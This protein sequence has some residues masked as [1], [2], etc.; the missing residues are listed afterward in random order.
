M[1]RINWWNVMWLAFAATAGLAFSYQIGFDPMRVRVDKDVGQVWPAWLQAVGSVIALGVAIT[2]P[3]RLYGKERDDLHRREI[4]EEQMR[5]RT[6]LLKAKAAA[7]TLL[8]A[9]RDFQSALQDAM[10]QLKDP[11]VEEYSWIK[12]KRLEAALTSFRDW[13]D[14]MPQMGKAGELG[15]DAIAA[16][17][18]FI[19]V[20]SDW[21]F[22]QTH[23]FNGKIDD[24]E[25]G[26]YAEFPEPPPLT[27]ILKRGIDRM[28]ESLSTMDGLFD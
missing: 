3:H 28:N 21:D 24:P 5:E 12:T 6:E 11:E 7:I 1:R 13:A 10:S 23:T 22:Y 9:A 26:L 2:V 19:R 16:A 27:H 8:P 15:L 18:S 25:R 4:R 17:E 14:R 20:L